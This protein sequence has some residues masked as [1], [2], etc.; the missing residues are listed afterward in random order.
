MKTVTI[1]DIR[2]IRN[3]TI[4]GGYVETPVSFNPLG[5]QWIGD[6]NPEGTRK[7]MSLKKWIKENEDYIIEM[8]EGSDVKFVEESKKK[9]MKEVV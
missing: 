7:G 4:W 5:D 9:K 1:K 8:I 2:D 6:L 3:Y